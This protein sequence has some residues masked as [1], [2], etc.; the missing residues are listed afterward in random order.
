MTPDETSLVPAGIEKIINIGH[1][2]CTPATMIEAALRLGLE[3]ILEE[4]RFQNYMKSMAA[5]NY[6][7]EQ[8]F[9]RS[10]QLESR[11]DILIEI[12]DEGMI[13]VN[14]RGEVFA[15]NQKAREITGVEAGTDWRAG[16]S[17]HPLSKGY[18]REK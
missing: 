2:P 5:C 9:K 15:I 11:F 6:S 3:R 7:F 12:L 16:V 14:E 10:R 1:R 13:G 18:E 17:L 4:K 8:M